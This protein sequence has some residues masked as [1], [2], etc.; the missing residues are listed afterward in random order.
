M[1]DEAKPVDVDIDL[2]NIKNIDAI[3]RTDPGFEKQIEASKKKK[4][5]RFNFVEPELLPLPSRGLLYRDCTDD[6]DVLNGRLRL[7][8]MTMKE[9]KVLSTTR[10]LKAGATTRIILDRCISS[11]I[12]AKDILLFDSN[13]LM[14]F[15]RKISYGDEYKF[16]ITC[17]NSICEMEF[18]HTLNISDLVFEELPEDFEE[19]IVVKLPKS[20]YTLKTVLP[21]L[22]H[23]EELSAKNANRKKSSDDED[24]RLVDNLMLTTVSI[25][26][27]D[28]KEINRAY[29]EEFFD[30]LPALD[31]AELRE[32]TDVSTGVDELKNVV[33]PYCETDY[34]GTIPIGPEFFRF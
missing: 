15:L 12:S 8:P 20:K 14:F 30:A 32:K 18:D 7:L 13:F 2:S 25:A 10:F 22:F 11:D 24:T 28:G 26:D 33:C 31:T 29:W 17:R 1:P 19:P 21:R 5:S 23:T 6:E 4:G 3:K 16:S 9:E 34:S 27:E